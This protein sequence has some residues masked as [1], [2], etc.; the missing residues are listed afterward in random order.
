MEEA[1]QRDHMFSPPEGWAVVLG[2]PVPASNNRGLI[3]I[4]DITH[5][6]ANP[7]AS[8]EEKEKKKGK[9][10]NRHR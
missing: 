9:L 2:L 3:A 4:S 8:E 6:G 10:E 7:H 1:Y 5:G